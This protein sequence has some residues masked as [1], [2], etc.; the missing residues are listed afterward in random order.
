MLCS[1]VLQ[2]QQN[3]VPL[4]RDMYLDLEKN[5]ACRGS[6]THA[7]LK[8]VIQSRADL[9]G[10]MG[11]RRD[12]TRNYYKLTEI[13]FRKHLLQVRKP[14]FSFNADVMLDLQIG[15]D[16]RDQTEFSDTTRFSQNTRGV[17]ISGDIG[18]RISFQTA[19]FENQVLYPQYLY[20]Y[21][22]D[23][24]VVPGQGRVKPFN[25][26]AYDFGWAMGNV[27]WSPRR[28]LNVQLGNGRHFVGHGYR[29]MLLSDATSP[30][31]YLK[32]SYLGL[33]DK[34]QYSTIYARLQMLQR[35]PAGESAESLFYWKRA[36]FNHLSLSLG[37]VDIG[38]FEGS[39]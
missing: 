34:L 17:W 18:P 39:I 2:A 8:P 10:V 7:G 29:S 19:F 33:Q 22:Q 30:F 16:F 26:R 9:T 15:Q 36:T 25:G 13:L 37:R 5:A 3:D 14:G 23:R 12:T 35:L 1:V 38:L 20:F 6:R 4:N 27:S 21:T 11:F 31:P 32:L 24:Q 28:W